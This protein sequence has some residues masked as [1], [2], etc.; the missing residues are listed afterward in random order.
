MSDHTITTF[1]RVPHWL[2]ESGASGGAIRLYAAMGKWA[3]NDTG[4][5]WPGR[6]TLAEYL[7]CS[8]KSVENWTKELVDLKALK[9][10]V[11]TVGKGRNQSNMY[12]LILDDPTNESPPHG[13]RTTIP[14]RANEDSPT[15]AN[16][17]SPELDPHKLDPGEL[18]SYTS[19]EPFHARTSS[20]MSPKSNPG[21]L[22][23]ATRKRLRDN[24]VLVGEARASG[25]SFLDD[26]TQYHWERFTDQLEK[27]SEHC[28]VLDDVLDIVVNQWSVTSNVA[29]PYQAG[30]E[31][32]MMI[33][34][35]IGA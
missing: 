22:D 28:H 7:Q 32:N 15:R 2:I 35:A 24:L 25:Y 20:S 10:E 1:T 3:D 11:R 13:G 12:T 17:A 9:K 26:E 8:V 34:K 27:E 30:I 18:D 23:E 19:S 4:R 14:P 29:D 21:D 31:L 5:A 33:H 16:D 6:K